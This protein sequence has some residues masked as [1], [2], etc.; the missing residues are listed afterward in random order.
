MSHRHVRLSF[1]ISACDRFQILSMQ[2]SYMWRLRFRSVYS[3]LKLSSK[4]VDEMLRLPVLIYISF[5]MHEVH[6][7]DILFNIK[8]NIVIYTGHLGLFDI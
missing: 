4:V 7:S 2:L 1:A 8:D 5:R 6:S 3:V